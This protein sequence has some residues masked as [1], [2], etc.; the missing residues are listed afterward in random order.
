MVSGIVLITSGAVAEAQDVGD[1]WTGNL[2]LYGWVPGIKG[3]QTLPNGDP[4]IDLS[5]K[6]VLDALDGAFFW[7]CR[8]SSW[9]LGPAL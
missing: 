5:G 2:T 8:S 6:D 1:D 3:D 4:L 9:S 7:G